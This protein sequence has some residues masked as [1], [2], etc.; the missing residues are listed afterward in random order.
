MFARDVH[1][2]GEAFR[3]DIVIAARTDEAG[4]FPE[5]QPPKKATLSARARL[6]LPMAFPT[7]DHAVI[8]AR[9]APTITWKGVSPGHQPCGPYSLRRAQ[10]MTVSVDEGRLAL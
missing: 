2:V 4:K 8:W 6:R 1:Q 7:L 5:P 3:L 9:T 10:K